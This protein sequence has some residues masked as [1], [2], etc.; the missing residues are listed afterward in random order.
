MAAADAEMNRDVRDEQTERVVRLAEVVVRGASDL[1]HNLLRTSVDL[2]EHQAVPFLS[3]AGCIVR[4]VIQH[5]EAVGENDVY[6]HE[7]GRRARAVQV[8]A[9]ICGSFVFTRTHWHSLTAASLPFPSTIQ[10]VITTLEG[11]GFP[12][13]H[14]CYVSILDSLADIE[15]QSVWSGWCV[16]V[17][18]YGGVVLSNTRPSSRALGL[19]RCVPHSLAVQRLRANGATRATGP[20]ASV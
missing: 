20:N 2:S 11:A 6:V 7:A 16:G 1:V 14:P 8:S 4:L 10:A 5:A 19:I 3:A 9:K 15:G 12:Q 17:G 18:G 13:Q